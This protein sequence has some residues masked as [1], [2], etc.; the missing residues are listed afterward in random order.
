MVGATTSAAAIRIDTVAQT[1]T[2]ELTNTTVSVETPL[3]VQAVVWNDE[4][5]ERLAFFVTQQEADVLRKMVAY[6][7]ER[8]KVSPSSRDVLEAI[9]PRLDELMQTMQAVS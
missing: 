6:I 1:V 5:D 9:V 3:P 8:V 7:L 4:A 2:V